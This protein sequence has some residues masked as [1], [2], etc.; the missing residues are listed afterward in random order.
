MKEGASD[1]FPSAAQV[2]CYIIR[3]RYTEGAKEVLEWSPYTH[4][5]IFSH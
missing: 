5:Q 1:F 4:N 2:L 3:E